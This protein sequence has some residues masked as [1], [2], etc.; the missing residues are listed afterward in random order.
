MVKRVQ[1]S[2]RFQFQSIFKPAPPPYFKWK[3]K[4]SKRTGS[5]SSSF[6]VELVG[7]DEANFFQQFWALKHV[8]GEK[9]EDFF[10]FFHLG[11]PTTP[12]F[13]DLSWK[14][15]KIF[16]FQVVLSPRPFKIL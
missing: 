8:H 5:I 1:K 14:T 3:S 2:C 16:M 11:G 12:E 4:N 7:N 15:P 6:G 9:I 10:S 13:G